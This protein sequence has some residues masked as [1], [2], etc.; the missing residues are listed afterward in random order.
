[1]SRTTITDWRRDLFGIWAVCPGCKVKLRLDHVVEATGEIS[2]SLDCPL[3]DF[4]AMATL[5]NWT[6]GRVDATAKPKGRT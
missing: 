2:P 4:H 5:A 6:H 1:M 3:C